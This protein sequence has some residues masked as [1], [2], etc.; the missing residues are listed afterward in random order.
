MFTSGC[1]NIGQIFPHYPVSYPGKVLLDS[2]KAAYPDECNGAPIAN[3][4]AGGV[5][6]GGAGGAWQG[7]AG[8]VW[9]GV[10]GADGL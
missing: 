3:N 10:G 7:G 5:C 8:G 1:V 4:G 2:N 6:L 9:L